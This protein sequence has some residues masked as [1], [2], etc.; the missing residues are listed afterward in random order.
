VAVRLLWDILAAHRAPHL[1]MQEDP[2]D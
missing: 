2:A 1:G